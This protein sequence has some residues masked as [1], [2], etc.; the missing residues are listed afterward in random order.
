MQNIDWKRKLTSRKF[1]MAVVGFATAVMQGA[2]MSENSIARV[3][4]ILMSGAVVI[5]YLV[6]EGLSD[7][8]NL[9]LPDIEDATERET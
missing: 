9:A 2:G 3:T 8:G 5:G 1:W 7:A 4:S 6:A